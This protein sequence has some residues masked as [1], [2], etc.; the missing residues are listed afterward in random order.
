MPEFHIDESL[1]KLI[2][3]LAEAEITQ[4]EENLKRDGC[5]DP[6][7]IWN[8]KN[9]LLDGHHRFEICRRN[10]IP[11]KTE[12]LT[13]PDRNAAKAWIIRN[14][15]GRR[16]LTPFVRAELALKLEP[17]IA[18]KA[19]ER[20]RAGKPVQN[21]AQGKTRDAIAK[22][23]GLSHDTIHKAKIVAEKAPEE[24]KT[25]LRAGETSINAAYRDIKRKETREQV[26][27]R[28]KES[29]LKTTTLCPILY[30]D[31]PWRY[32][33]SVSE[34][35]DIEN[36]YPTME[37]ED[38][39]AL[40][41]NDVAAPNAL[42]FLWATSP[43]LREAMTVLER[44]GFSYRTCMVWVKDKIGMGYYA[45]QKHEILLIAKRGELPPPDPK[46]RPDSVI[47]APRGKH[48]QKPEV[49]Y[50]LIERMYPELDKIEL[51]SRN[52]RE[53]WKAWGNESA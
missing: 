41:I 52:R 26:I 21:S 34:S 36:Q 27:D 29:P 39:C 14:Q 35:R 19:K 28:L 18:T 6:L 24:V 37:L 38:I 25:K 11:Y 8:G 51:F 53:G 50:E 4:L 17:L 43:K 5:R 20:M 3:T 48:S 7:V 2:P 46:N 9:I 47:E 40:P 22:A 42:L 1:R 23:A 45:R 15:F 33:H 49:V 16:N 13:L 30:A 12:R 32:E 31:P 10:Q 44:W